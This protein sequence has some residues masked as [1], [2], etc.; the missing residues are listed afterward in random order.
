MT[1]ESMR[2]RFGET[3]RSGVLI[4][5]S[6]RQSAP[7]I[8]G[9]VWL[10]LWLMAQLPLVGMLGPLAGAVLSFGR[11][12]RTPLYEVATPG[13]RVWWAHR[14]GRATW[15]RR[16]L[17]AT[18]TT[19]DA[20]LPELL[21]GLELVDVE[22][23]WRTGRRTVGVI[24]DRKASSV[25]VVFTASG[26][27]FAVASHREQDGIVAGWGAALAPLARARCGVSRVTWQEWSHPVG[28][29]GHREFLAGLTQPTTTAAVDYEEL[30]LIQD[31]V[32]ISHE[33]L[34][35]VTVEL[36][37]VR[38]RRADTQTT[39]AVEALVD[40]VRQLSARF[41]T[42][43]I[44]VEVP[45]SP[46]ELSAVIRLRSD[47]TRTQRL[48]DV[49]RGLAAAVG[50]GGLEWG[51]MAVAPAWGLC[52]VDGSVHRSYRIAGW[53]M[54]PV[55]ADWL[56]PLLT[57]DAATRTVTMVLEPVPL[58]RAAAEAN[59][60]LTSIES[61]L[62]QKE[63]HG[64]RLTAR[65]RRRQADVEGRERELAE[66]HP[67]FRHIGIITVTAPTDDLLDEACGRVEQAA[68][69]SLLDLRLLAAR[70][71]EGW[72]AS[73]PLGRSVRAGGWL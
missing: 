69:Q 7:L 30:L 61:D 59:R 73:L 1:V 44:S 19:S 72:V 8:A 64:F 36:R 5:L 56:Q 29:A 24:R 16:S 4:G 3:A 47:P 57:G 18:A 62:S 23:D 21:A 2:Y 48:R 11:F 63:R 20:D 15:I 58:A 10:T 46:V 38:A 34:I 35:T 45:L 65:E 37:R 71:G 25:S 52:R 41:D 14:R 43:G 66:G 26:A 40:E 60:Q 17:L 54:L 6:M 28:V 70:Q 50:R 39:A 33:V 67:E 13:V 12:R 55:K 53:P 9:V 42:H 22:A 27:A 49:R 32:T 31:P 68:A 51:P